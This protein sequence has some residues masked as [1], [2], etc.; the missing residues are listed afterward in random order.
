MT[1]GS[2]FPAGNGAHQASLKGLADAAPK[3]KGR[4]ADVLRLLELAGYPGHTRLELAKLIGC[5]SSSVCAAVVKLIESGL[6]IELA[7][8]RTNPT[9]S[10]AG[11]I[12]LPC[13]A[14]GRLLS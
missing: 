10:D 6:V 7:E 2:L 11:I 12:V 5:E 9:G 1:Q 13:W 14:D 8:R 3:L 4:K